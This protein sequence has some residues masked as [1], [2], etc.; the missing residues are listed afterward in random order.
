[1]RNYWFYGRAYPTEANIAVEQENPQKPLKTNNITTNIRQQNHQALPETSN[2][3]TKN[4]S[5]YDVIFCTP[6][7]LCVV[8]TNRSKIELVSY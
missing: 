5:A 8:M 3:I 7:P 2:R 6:I 1:M 4:Q